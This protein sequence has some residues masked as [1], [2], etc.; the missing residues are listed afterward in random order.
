MDLGAQPA[1]RGAGLGCLR[2]RGVVEG[3]QAAEVLVVSWEAL[4][5]PLL[6]LVVSWV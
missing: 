2:L 6:A 3:R 5:V 4:W 1:V